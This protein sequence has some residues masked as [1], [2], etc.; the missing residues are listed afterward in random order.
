MQLRRLG[1]IARTYS[2]INRYRQI[3]TV[4]FKYGFDGIIDRLNLGRYIEMGARLLS[5]KRQEELDNLNNY[6]RIRMV[7]EELGPTFVKM[8]QVLSTRPDLIPIE[9][10]EE[11]SK[12]QDD[13]QPFPF[14]EAKT[15]IEEELQ[16]PLE[17]IFSTFDETPIAAA[18]IA[19]VHRAALIT[20]EDVA[21]KIQRPGISKTIGQDIGIL[22]Q[23]AGLLEH[24]IEELRLY[25][26][27]R[28][29][30]EFARTI[31]KEINFHLEASH[32]E[33]FARQF[34]DNPAIYVPRVFRH[35]ST[36][37]LL[38][39]EY[40]E[41]IKINDIALLE[42]KGYNLTLLAARGTDLI[43]EQVFIH[44]F[45]HADPHPGNM[46]V[47][48]GNVICTLDFG[49]MG[50]LDARD[51]EHF[52]E[53]I[54]GYIH[55]DI[56]K[57]T[58]AVL[59]VV[60]FHQEP[61]RRLLERDIATFADLHLY[62]PLKDV[63]VGAILEDLIDLT[64]RHQ[65]RLPPDIFFM[66][67]AMTQV[68]SIGL[69]LDPDFDITV[70]VRP[71]IKRL[72]TERL[73]PKQLLLQAFESTTELLGHLRDLPEDLLVTLR[74][75]RQGKLQIGFEHR[76]LEHLIFELNRS[77]NR[78]A[79]AL[80]IAAIV[81]GSSFILAAEIGPSFFGLSVIGLLGFSLAGFLGLALLIFIIRSGIL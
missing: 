36:E 54:M 12:L 1:G 35:A 25:R 9:M 17:E 49:M 78:L 80:I 15:I 47:L 13:V 70:R 65:L 42:A 20:G 56:P 18:S 43:L 28:I 10:V 48:P 52:T 45:F 24:Y 71:F 6:E 23:L 55:R 27:S 40:I 38:T 31:R 26:P 66:I 16:A 79:F 29:V 37:R 8:G 19:Q 39:M 73:Q 69:Q 67:K 74:Q 61:D 21:V 58:D 68:E 33:R 53:F 75:V 72:I 5:R 50:H 32:A 2:N 46:F 11:L 14:A 64:S 57:I 44:G 41:G 34:R 30:D 7:C 81:I 62:K 59:K 76:G 60:E 3:L 51:R 77:S 4:L 22:F 63:R